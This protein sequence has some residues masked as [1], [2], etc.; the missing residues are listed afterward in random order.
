[1]L[2]KINSRLSSFLVYFIASL[3]IGTIVTY[4]VLGGV[5][6][7]NP[8]R[9][10]WIFGDNVTA[11]LAQLYFLSDRWRIPLTSNPDYGSEHSTPLTYTGPNIPLT[12]IQKLLQLN[13]ELQFFGVWIWMTISLQILFG[14]FIAK[15]INASWIQAI[16]F[17]VLTITPFFLARFQLHFWLTP[18]FLILW[19]LLVA[20]RFFK[21]NRLQTFS[22]LV[23]INLSL[24]LAPY[25]LMMVL[26]VIF[27]IALNSIIE[28]TIATR[29]VVLHAL[30][31]FASLV[32]TKSLFDGLGTQS[33]SYESFKI[34]FSGPDY[35]KFPYNLISFINPDVGLESYYLGL[36]NEYYLT[37]NFSSSKLSFG[38]SPGSYEGYLYLG[39]GVL[40]L[41]CILLSRIKKPSN[42]PVVFLNKINRRLFMSIL[43]AIILFSVTYNVS[44][45]NH[46]LQIP[47][48]YTGKWAFS[49]FRSSGRFMWLIAYMA[50]VLVLLMLISK[51]SKNMLTKVLIA[52]VVLNLLDLS[53]PVY[54]R[55]SALRQ[56][57]PPVVNF[58]TLEFEKFKYFAEGKTRVISF[59]P[60]HGSPNWQE[61]NYWAFKMGMT[62][63]SNQTGRIN[64]DLL[65][66][67][68]IAT[69]K[70]I[71][72]GPIG[73]TDLYVIHK[74]LIETFASCDLS[75]FSLNR[76]GE[77]LILKN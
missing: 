30:V 48:P 58:K 67:E 11:Y 47:F 13:P 55:F 73:T 72:D 41:F 68:S 22:T 9:F 65:K 64:F 31:L 15:E 23:L 52:A 10:D 32:F 24:L 2:L 56:E 59:P 63:N 70:I 62:T 75:R 5:S 29:K 8:K 61:L 53:I 16:L 14:I 35:G 12:L 34:N 28:R 1:M 69:F 66:R 40:F 74:D 77:L 36:E 18:H 46:V 7:L 27:F 50:L 54:E 42:L 21:Y 45:G 49:A 4:L 3:G 6:R 26:S 44:F 37:T 76:I 19:S 43:V 17:S 51:F 25:I 71:C 60:G 33:N 57:L 20:L 38:A 39:A